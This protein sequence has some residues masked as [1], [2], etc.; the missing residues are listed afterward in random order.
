MFSLIYAWID[1]WINIREAGDLRRHRVHYDAIVMMTT[2]H[3]HYFH[4]TGL[5]SGQST[6]YNWITLTQAINVEGFK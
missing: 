1:G 5:L 3:G 6:G 4:N 2:W